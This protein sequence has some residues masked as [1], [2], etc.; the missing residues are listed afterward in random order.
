[1]VWATLCFPSEECHLGV[2]FTLPSPSPLVSSLWPNPMG[3]AYYRHPEPMLL[4]HLHQDQP[5]PGSHRR[6]RGPVQQLSNCSACICPSGTHCPPWRGSGPSGHSPLWVTG[7]R[8]TTTWQSSPG[9]AQPGPCL[10]V[11]PGLPRPPPQSARRPHRP[12]VS[13]SYLPSS[14]LPW[15]QAPAWNAS[16]LCPVSFCVPIRPQD[17]GH[18]LWEAFSAIRFFKPSVSFPLSTCHNCSITF[19]YVTIYV[20]LPISL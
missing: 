12:S 2:P 3:T 13:L 16:P 11:Q 20:Y 6:P 7:G 8:R 4:S 14:F 9:P 5:S 19:V 18:F 1:M 17:K 10:P 15:V